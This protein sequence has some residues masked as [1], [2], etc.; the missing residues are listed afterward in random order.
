M[1]GDK[2]IGIT[3]IAGGTI[4]IYGGLKGYSPLKAIQNVI[5]GKPG[6]T[7]Q[8]TSLLSAPGGTNSSTNSSAS[9]APNAPGNV[10]GN[11]ALG[12]Q[13]AAAY[14][15]DSGSEWDSLYALWNKESGWNERADNPKSGAYG[16]PQSLPGSKMASAGADWQTNPATQIKWGLG[17]IKSTYGDANAAW[18]H[19]QA[20]D[21]Y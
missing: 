2:G 5:Q 18:A 16:I 15:W 10:T 13:M 1:P 14:G 12:K 7:G 20:K 8:S 21:W 19:E 6:N 4:L 9:S 17:Y 11:V 3:A